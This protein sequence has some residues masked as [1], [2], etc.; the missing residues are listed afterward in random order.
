MS[1]LIGNTNSIKHGMSYT[2]IYMTWKNIKKRCINPNCKDYKNYGGRGITVCYEWL[3]FENF[4]NDM[5]ES[6]LEN[7]KQYGE[8]NTTIERKCNDKGYSK[9]NCKW[10]TRSEQNS[11]QRDNINQKYFK[12]TRVHDNYE[13]LSNNQ[14]DFSRKYSLDRSAISHCL[15]GNRKSHKGWKFLPY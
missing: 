5:Y 1:P 14:H 10:A 12:A 13:E 7:I 8:K 11:N 4:K 6:Y 9:E 2:R 3:E 15:K